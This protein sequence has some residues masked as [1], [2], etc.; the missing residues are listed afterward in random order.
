MA[1]RCRLGAGRDNGARIAWWIGKSSLALA[2][3]ASVA[4]GK[5]LLGT[6]IYGNDLS[7]L[8]INAEDSRTEMLRRLWALASQ[9]ISRSRLWPACAYSALTTGKSSNR[10]S[11]GPSEGLRCCIKLEWN[12]SELLDEFRPDLV[13]LDPLVSL[14]A[15]GNMNDNGVMSS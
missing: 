12:S 1:I 3:A 11:C 8:Y 2:I 6:R 13:V 4:A 15:G 10:H 7:A 9:H 14:C 5:E